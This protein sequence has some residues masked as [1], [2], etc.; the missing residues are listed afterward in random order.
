MAKRGRKPKRP[1]EKQEQVKTPEKEQK[2][3][4]GVPGGGQ[5]RVDEVGRSGVYPASGPLPPSPD[6]PVRGQASWGQGERG[7]EGYQDSG[8]SEIVSEQEAKQLREEYHSSRASAPESISRDDEQ[9]RGVASGSGVES[10]C[11]EV[12]TKDPVCCVPTDTVDRAAQIMK[13]EDVGSVPVVED[14]QTHKLIGIITDRDL[15]LKVVAE[16]RD[17]LG[18][19]V[20]EVMTRNPV[21]CRPDD[22]LQRALQLMAENQVRRIPV[23]DEDGRIIGIIAQADM[24]TRIGEPTKTAEVVREI[25][26]PSAAGR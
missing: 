12:M 22:K 1:E 19:R 23:V 8:T 26:E 15:A 7:A 20:E 11:R 14:Q 5:G 6:A 16:E 21:T 24:A 4:S 9:R 13:A 18:T 25:S 3:E 10:A 2:R 17:P